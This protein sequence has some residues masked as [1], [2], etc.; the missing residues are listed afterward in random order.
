MDLGNYG[1]G[2]LKGID[3][4]CGTGGNISHL[5]RTSAEL[6]I[7]GLDS[8]EKQ[9]EHAKR[10]GL[11]NAFIHASMSDMVSVRNEEY[12]FSYAINSIHHLP[13]IETQ[14]RT[15]DEVYRI[16]RPDGIFIVHEINAKNP[17]IRFYMNHVFPR[18]RS[19]DDGSEIWLTE[20]LVRE[21]KFIV[22]EIDYFT[23]VPDFTP[24]LM[25]GILTKLDQ[26]LSNSMLSVLGAH[27]MYV[28]RKPSAI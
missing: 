5:Q 17:I 24:A 1:S 28:L 16:L 2:Q 15:F 20:R 23:F 19:I 3:L 9:I 27:V 6:A 4:G 22:E 14:T 25:M 18:I 11:T 13:S 12:D 8:S 10:K 21:T 7:D 26:F